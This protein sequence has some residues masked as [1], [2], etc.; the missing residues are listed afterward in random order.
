MER[1]IGKTG[2]RILISLGVLVVLVFVGRGLTSKPAAAVVEEKYIPVQV[3][4]AG[5]KTLTNTAILSGKITSDTDVSVIPKVPGK[6]DSV[7]VNVGDPVKKGDILFTLDATDLRSAFQLANARYQNSQE[8]WSAAKASLERT[9]TLAAGKITDAQKNLANMKA[10]F[11]A[12]AVSKV[13]LDQTTLGV[14]EL[15]ATFASQ[16]EQLQVQAS[17][18][19]LELAQVQL[20]QAREA[21]DNATVTAPVAGTVSQVNVQVGNMAT[22]AQAAI[23]LTNTGSVYSSL[24][25]AENLVNRLTKDKAVKVKVPSVSET[26]IV[27]KIENISPSSDPRTQLYPLKISFENPN[28]LIKPGMFAKVELTTEEKADVMAIKSEAVVLKNEK[29][30]VYVVEGDKAVAKEVVTGLDTGVDIEILKGLNLDD[31][32]IIKGQTL[33]DEGRKVKVV[34]GDAS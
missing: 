11:E 30:I 33:V 8:L 23:G 28:G 26:N 17:D 25:V 3:E 19:S 2:K 20:A 22:S 1:K 7:L 34:G 12:G 24:S 6:V 27:G 10:L 4:A 9:K 5:K 16:I 31:K 29:T 13:Q 21:L 32:V 18:S 14:K 15:E